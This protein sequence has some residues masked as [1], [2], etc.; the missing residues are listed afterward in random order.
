VRQF[1]NGKNKKCGLAHRSA[2]EVGF[3]I[4]ELLTVMSIIVILISLLTP[5]LNRV[6]R[7]AMDVKQKA[8]FH[9]IAAGLE[10]FNSENDGYPDSNAVDDIGKQYCGAMRL[11][12]AMVGQDLKGFNPK[13]HF[14]R[15]EFD[16]VTPTLGMAYPPYGTCGG[17]A[18]MPCYNDNIKSRKR[19]LE[20]EN[21]NV[22]QLR[23]IYDSGQIIAANLYDGQNVTA[24]FD[25]CTFVLC[26]S[27]T[28]ITNKQTGR[29]MGMPILYYRAEPSK[30]G[31]PVLATTAPTLSTY[32]MC[33]FIY[34]V[35]DNQALIDM[36]LPWSPTLSHPL[37]S[38]GTTEAGVAI[39]DWPKKFYD[40]IRDPKIDSGD[41]PYKAESF[42]FISAGFDGQYGTTDDIYNFMQ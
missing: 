12:E 14:T 10:L 27:Y 25:P 13:S 37:A 11:A 35:R 33:Q 28:K 26:D 4:I 36:G 29:K 6:R 8:Q 39:T 20:L 15:A 5:A 17:P 2:S 31:D 24:G 40:T 21:A 23:D 18:D 30:I 32:P 34:N 16:S 19:Y 9:A 7:F 3:T 22:Y 38:G 41:K 1:K 42:I